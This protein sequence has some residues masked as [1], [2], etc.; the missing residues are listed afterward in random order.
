MIIVLRYFSRGWAIIP[1]IQEKLPVQEDKIVVKR[2]SAAISEFYSWSSCTVPLTVIANRDYYAD[3]HKE[4]WLLLDTKKVKD[5]V[6]SRQEYRLRVSTE[7]RYRHLKCFSNLANFTTRS[8]SMVVNQVIFVLLTYSLLQFFLLKQ[9]R[10]KLNK[11]TLP[12][13]R[14][15]LLPSDS[16]IIVYWNNYYGLFDNYE[17][18]EFI[19][20]LDEEPRKKIAAKCRRLRREMTD[21]LKNPRPP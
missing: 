5:P 10:K 14:Q 21:G 1:K 15:Q 20:M 18:T 11:K 19:T 3:G 12:G 16:Y 8:F 13:I 9:N 17:Y 2:E 6:L 7:E 4:T